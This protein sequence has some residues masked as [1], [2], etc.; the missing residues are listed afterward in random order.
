MVRSRRRTPGLSE[1]STA[2]GFRKAISDINREDVEIIGW[3]YMFS[4]S[5]KKDQLI[6]RVV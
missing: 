2:G 6:G 3:L 4:I 1:G 5:E